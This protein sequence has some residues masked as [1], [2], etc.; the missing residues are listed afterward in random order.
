[1]D[2]RTPMRRRAY[3]AGAAGALAGLAGCIGGE[4]EYQVTGASGASPADHPLSLDV[5]V[6]SPSIT[7]DSPGA[8]SFTLRN[9]GDDAV[10]VRNTGVWPL[11]VLAVET[12]TE[13]GPV[14][15]RLLSDRYGETDR[16]EVKPSGMSVSQEPLVRPIPA[17]ESVTERYVLH[18]DGLIQPGTYRLRAKFEEHILRYAPPGTDPEG[19][20]WTDFAPDVTVTLEAQSVLP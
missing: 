15:T 10:A 1:M 17:D 4:T 13:H 16:I 8:L 11:G 5:A 7:V 18:G 12:E 2:D 14:D 3:L 20:D 9:G 19:G 6:E